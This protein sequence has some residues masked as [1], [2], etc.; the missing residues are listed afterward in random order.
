MC[1]AHEYA[2]SVYPSNTRMGA[3]VH[4]FLPGR[5]ASKNFSRYPCV[6]SLDATMARY[7]APTVITSSIVHQLLNFVAISITNS[8]YQ[9][10]TQ[11]NL[12]TQQ[13]IKKFA[14]VL[15]QGMGALYIS[16]YC[17]A[18]SYYFLLLSS[19]SIRGGTKNLINW[20][21]EHVYKKKNF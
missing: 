12:V 21:L 5:T 14:I 20:S 19:I 7:E 4:P 16:P 6:V 2:P 9:S 3:L 11:C 8:L 1:I 18:P 13:L 17:K 15:L 10:R